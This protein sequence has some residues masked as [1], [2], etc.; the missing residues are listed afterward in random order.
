M[1]EAGSLAHARFTKTL[2]FGEHALGRKNRN[3]KP[4]RSPLCES[5]AGL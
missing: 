1:P 2:H 3:R 5:G 4:D